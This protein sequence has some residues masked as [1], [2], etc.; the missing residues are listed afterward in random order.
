MHM[1][2]E[3][4]DFLSAVPLRYFIGLT[5]F[6][7]LAMFRR[8][9]FYAFLSIYLRHYLG[10]SVTETTLFATLPMIVNVLAQTLI[11][12]TISDR[13]QL[14]RTLII[15]GETLAAF[16][17]VLVWYIHRRFADP[18]VSGYAIIVGLTAIEIFWSMSNISWSAL[19][20]DIYDAQ[21]RSRVQ[22]W[23]ASLGGVGRMVGVWI[24]G[25]LYDG[26][27]LRAAG[28]GFFEGPLFFVA[29][30][31]MLISTL[32]LFFLPEGGIGAKPA[33]VAVNPNHGR[34][35]AST[36]IYLL[37]LAGMVFINFGRNS[38]AIIFTQYLILDPGPGFDSRTLSNVV[39]TQS[40][41]IVA[42]GWTAGW[43]CRRIG[44]AAALLAGTTAAV[45][46][47]ALLA[48]T[49]APS[50]IYVACF[51]RGVG[52]A[53]IMAA[54]YTFASILIPP[55]MR[56]RMFAWFNGTFFLSFGMGGTLIAG[57]IVDGLIAAGYA[58]P[59]AYRL[60]FAAGAGLT[61]IGLLIQ[62]TLLW[63]LKKV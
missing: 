48:L 37:F 5:S 39:N 58:Q 47:L 60:S 32:P 10:L 22:G 55:Q 18:I 50:M 56:A 51:L 17:T 11:W 30:G 12:G 20:S 53:V 43:I 3:E 42:L 29:A 27:G 4:P 1:Q 9:L 31:V 14:R 52:D 2:N 62:A 15:A 40:F 41:A 16:G 6:E 8:G 13:L 33:P 61:V 45:A 25:L 54:A 63:F 57:P 59:W 28:W 7:M 35:P 38:I 21:Q 23:L 26:L 49:T 34:T 44:N 46:G 24:G 36:S 19:V